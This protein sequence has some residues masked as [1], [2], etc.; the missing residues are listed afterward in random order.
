[1]PDSVAF[2]ACPMTERLYYADAYL[3]HFSGTVVDRADEG[4]RVYLDRTAFYPTSGGQPHD[5]G[6]LGGI[7]V[8]NVV[9]EED[10]VAHVLA[11]PLS[12]S[13]VTGAI[14]WPRRFDFMQQH[15]GQHVLSAVFADLLGYQTTSVHF[16]P[17]S[18]TLDLDTDVVSSPKLA[19]AMERA[20]EIV[21]A[22]QLV[23]V[24]F[25]DAATATGLRKPSERDGMLRIVAIRDVDRSACGGTHVRATGEI[26]PILLRRQEKMKQN[27]RVEFLCGMRAVRRAGADFDVLT[28]L[29]VALSASIDELAALHGVGAGAPWCRRRALA[30]RDS[31]YRPYRRSAR[32]CP[33]LR[34]V[35]PSDL[36]GSIRRSPGIDHCRVGGLRG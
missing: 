3:T 26:G 32:L 2:D 22:N 10:R 34:R 25:E 7:A 16:G 24:A 9:D 4:R 35:A 21:T 27:A 12:A 30:S 33:R 17:A 6:T 14:D 5:L 36:P 19:K 13:A 1:M 15:T 29:A 23:D 31:A 28:K 18:S 11:S 8:T 20:N